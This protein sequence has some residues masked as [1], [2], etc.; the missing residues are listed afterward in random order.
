[1]SKIILIANTDWYLHHFRISLARFLRVQGMDVVLV[2]PSGRYAHEIQ[3]E[4]FRWRKWQ[5]E[6]QTINPFKEIKALFGL[7][8]IFRDEDP[9]LVHLH[10]IKPVLYGSLATKFVKVPALIRSITGRGYVF[11]GDDVRTLFLRFLV[12]GIYRYAIRSDSNAT[13]FENET[14]RQ[15][16]LKEGL[17]NP[18]NTYLIE[19]V[20]VDTD[21]FVPTPEPTGSPVIVLP[22]RMLWDKGVGTFVDAIR[23]LK[24]K[25][26]ARFVLV[27]EPDPGNPAN[28][29]LNQIKSWENEGLVEWWGWQADMRSVFAACHIVVLS[30]FAEGIPTVLLEAAA[31]GRAIV[32]TD[33]PGCRDV[34]IDGKTGMLVPKQN[35]TAL[36]EALETLVR[37]PEMRRAMGQAGRENVV[38][39]FAATR[40]NEKTFRIY[41]KYLYP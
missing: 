8:R 4:G 3:A 25:V 15:Y 24:N 9:S 19:G 29:E 34:V 28:I 35:P 39:R 7:V 13:I 38:I 27:G 21:Y 33:V 17:I 23:A 31:S 37:H 22:S 20:G 12:K 30:S 10:T 5:V 32:A 14:D 1:M 40:V 18:T 41:Q 2:S 11:L 26:A 36:A 6:R 16:F